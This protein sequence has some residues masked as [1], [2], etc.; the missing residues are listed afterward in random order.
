MIGKVILLSRLDTDCNKN[1]AAKNAKMGEEGEEV[2]DHD[3]HDQPMGEQKRTNCLL[4]C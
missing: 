3:V 4:Q 2:N 1:N